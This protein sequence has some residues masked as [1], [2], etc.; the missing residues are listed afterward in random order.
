MNNGMY[1]V[2]ENGIKSFINKVKL[3][4]GNCASVQDHAS[5]LN[6]TS[7]GILKI[8]W[9]ELFGCTGTGT[10]NSLVVLR[11]DGLAASAALYQQSNIKFDTWGYATQRFSFLAQSEL[12][13][14]IS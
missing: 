7:S 10:D 6:A 4:N 12:L 2:D 3:E 5:L 9:D 1:F 13:Y 11:A 8:W 14:W